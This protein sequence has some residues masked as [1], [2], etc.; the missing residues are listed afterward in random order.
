[1]YMHLEKMASNLFPDN[2]DSEEENI[3]LPTPSVNDCGLQ[4]TTGLS[5]W[6]ETRIAEPWQQTELE[7]VHS[8]AAQYTIIPL[9][10]SLLSLTSRLRSSKTVT[11]LSATITMQTP[12]LATH[13]WRHL[14]RASFWSLHANSYNTK[15]AWRR[16]HILLI[17]GRNGT[18]YPVILITMVTDEDRWA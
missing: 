5:V 6:A 17:P 4:A 18:L 11:R 13:M 12:V 1:M 2:T 10:T 9:W 14:T 16:P 7:L 15:I 3:V 8:T